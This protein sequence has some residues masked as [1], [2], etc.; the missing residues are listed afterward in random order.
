M[1]Q[2]SSLPG[3]IEVMPLTSRTLTGEEFLRGDAQ[4]REVALAGELRLP[5]GT[6]LADA[7]GKVAAVVLVHGS[8][9][10]SGAI[11]VW[12]RDLNSIGIAAFIL[13]S[14]SGRGI[15]NTIADQ[16][17]INSLAMITDAYRALDLLTAHPGIRADRIGV[18]GFSKGAVASVYSAMDRFN[19]LYGNPVR[20]FAAHIGLYT[21]CNVTYMDDTAVARVPLRLFHGIADDYVSIVPCREYVARLRQAGADATLT[22][23]PGAH[24]GFDN[25]S[26]APLTPLQN[27]QTTR[28]CRMIEGPGGA[29]HDAQTGQIYSLQSAPCVETGA[30]VGYDAVAATAVR[31]AVK[32]ILTD[33]LL[34]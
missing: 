10:I 28:N 9:G 11:D 13:D 25:P 14:F 22:E 21:P 23:Y 1:G 15:V 6:A 2:T 34:R 18:L 27:A 31:V 17:Q 16:S 24:H 26:Y 7:G 29:I 3:R 20:R 5:A 8:G 30:H 33:V 32:E 19:Q 12:A 4:G